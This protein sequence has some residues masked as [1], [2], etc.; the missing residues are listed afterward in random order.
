MK[1]PKELVFPQHVSDFL[2]LFHS[3]VFDGSDGVD[4]W[5]QYLTIIQKECIALSLAIYYQCQ[6]C[7][8][9]HTKVLCKLKNTTQCNVLTKN[10]AS[11][12]L[13]LRTDIE[14]IS[15]IEHDRWLE[16]WDQLSLKISI[17]FGDAMIPPLI[18]L[19][20][21]IARNDV[22]FIK[23][24][25]EQIKNYNLTINARKLIGEL[26]SVVVFMKAATSKNRIIDKIEQVLVS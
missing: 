22:T 3:V 7:I 8:N 13:F 6:E 23:M 14:H 25:G 10:I 11:M 17:K 26:T 24:F 12:I 15:K 21:G 9:Y 1:K 4:E 19:S 5:D 16:T 20:I 18:G 2:N